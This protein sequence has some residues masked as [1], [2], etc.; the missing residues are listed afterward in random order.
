[1]FLEVFRPGESIF[2]GPRTPRSTENRF[3]TPFRGQISV[4]LGSKWRLPKNRL[5]WLK[6]IKISIFGHFLRHPW[7]PNRAQN[8]SKYLKISIFYWFFSQKSRFF[9]NRHFD[10]K[11]TEIWPL[12]G[13]KNRF[14]VD[15]RVLG[16][17][18]MDSPGRKTPKNIFLKIFRWVFSGF[19]AQK[20]PKIVIFGHFL[21]FG[22]F[23]DF[24]PPPDFDPI[25]LQKMYH[26]VEK[27]FQMDPK[28]PRLA[29]EP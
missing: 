8:W 11:M 7:G 27:S 22:I 10:P 14:S 25:P 15:L 3:W 12:K 19:W 6:I 28:V 23:G 16:P 29:P 2:R 21:D 24:D 9:D 17:R 26:P 5:F 18:K 1:M 4:I 13:V 20:V